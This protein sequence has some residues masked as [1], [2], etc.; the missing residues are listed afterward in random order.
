M[1]RPPL[2]AFFQT[3]FGSHGECFVSPWVCPWF[4]RKA[5]GEKAFAVAT[6]AYVGLASETTIS[7]KS[8]I[9]ENS[10]KI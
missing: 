5:H 9:V 2:S 1:M 3:C 8:A 10:V 4:M 6:S 7:E